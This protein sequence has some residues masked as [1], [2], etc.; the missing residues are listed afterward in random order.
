MKEKEEDIKDISHVLEFFNRTTKALD[1]M[2]EQHKKDAYMLIC[3]ET[4]NVDGEERQLSHVAMGGN[5]STLRRAVFQGLKEDENFNSVVFQA[6]GKFA[7]N[8]IIKGLFED[9]EGDE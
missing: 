2:K 3:V 7:K 5:S 4:V 1:V 6:A 9:K 8:E